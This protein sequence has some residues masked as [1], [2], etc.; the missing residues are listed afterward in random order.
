MKDQLSLSQA[1]EGFFLAK[2]A[3]GKS[4]YTIRNYRLDLDR[5]AG[6]L[7][8]DVSFAEINT[9]DL[10]RFLRYL[11]DE[12]VP[13]PQEPERRLSAKTARNTY[14]TLSSAWT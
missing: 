10:R 9:N 12:F 13:K 14:V 5:L 7:G 2:N 3:E 6:F 11:Q 1:V 8:A 4:H